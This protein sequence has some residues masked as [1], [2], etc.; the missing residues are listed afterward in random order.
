MDVTTRDVVIAVM[1]LVVGWCG[2]ILWD[3]VCDWLTDTFD[4]GRSMLY[5]LFAL[6]EAVSVAIAVGYAVT[7]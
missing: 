5:D 2:H 7:H 1:F 4:A 6:C 3:V